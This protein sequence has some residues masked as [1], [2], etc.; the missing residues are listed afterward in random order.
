[1]RGIVVTPS[2]DMEVRDFGYPLY[3]TVGEAVDGPIELVKP[4]GLPKPFCMIV[5][6][7]GLLR[8]NWSFNPMGSLV[9]GTFRHGSPIVGT[10]VFMKLGYTSEGPDVI[11][12][13]ESDEAY[14]KAFLDHHITVLKLLLA[15]P[16]SKGEN[17]CSYPLKT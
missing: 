16:N 2:M 8:D 17:T 4:M 7:E 13:D 1:M 14:L 6:G 3:K 10:V 11:G 15:E 12:L 5:N 9:Y